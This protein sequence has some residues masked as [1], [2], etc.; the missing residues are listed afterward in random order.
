MGRAEIEIYHPTLLDM[1]SSQNGPIE[2]FVWEAHLK[3]KIIKMV[4]S[5]GRI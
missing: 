4:D 5:I 2:V 3:W 1:D